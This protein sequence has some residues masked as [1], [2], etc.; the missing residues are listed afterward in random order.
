MNTSRWDERSNVL[1]AEATGNRLQVALAPPAQISVGNPHK[2]LLDVSWKVQ[3]LLAGVE[4]AVY[5][6]V[7]HIVTFD[8]EEANVVRRMVKLTTDFVLSVFEV[9]NVDDQDVS[10]HVAVAGGS[11]VVKQQSGRLVFTSREEAAPCC[12]P[13][14]WCRR[15]RSPQDMTYDTLTPK[16]CTCL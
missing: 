7:G 8:V 9:R 11:H 4:D 16:T 13:V 5:V 1:L 6:F 3:K 15:F 12:Q 10:Y 2:S 14:R